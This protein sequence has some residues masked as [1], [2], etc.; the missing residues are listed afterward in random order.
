MWCKDIKEYKNPFPNEPPNIGIDR[1]EGVHAGLI[2]VL[3][4]KIYVLILEFFRIILPVKWPPPG[5]P[6]HKFHNRYILPGR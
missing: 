6:R 5:R 1:H 3:P 2:N 4:F